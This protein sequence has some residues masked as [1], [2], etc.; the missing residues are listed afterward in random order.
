MLFGFIGFAVVSEPLIERNL[1]VFGN[2]FYNVNSLLLFADDYAEFDN[3][4]R[5][6]V[7]PS[8]A[9]EDYFATHSVG[10][11][12][13]REL[14]GLVWEAFIMLRSLGP[15]G[16]DDARILVGIPLAVCCAIG[17]RFE[18]RPAKYLLIGWIA[19]SWVVF[20]WY[21]PIA[22]GDRFP[23]PLL[24]PVLAFT[25]EGIVRLARTQRT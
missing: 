16:L 13:G 15:Q 18:R 19:A 14:N 4:L 24:L 12:L 8:E 10:V 7:L 17:L 20:A 1:R 22:A 3:M 5:G 25:A 11:M 2:P 9:A 6:G 21:V 23:I